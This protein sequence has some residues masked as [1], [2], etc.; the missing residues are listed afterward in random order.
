MSGECEQGKIEE[1]S[2]ML[3]EAV[4]MFAARLDE[5]REIVLHSFEYYQKVDT[6]SK[7]WWLPW[8]LDTTSFFNTYKSSINL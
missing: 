3:E 1:E 5:R 6:V 2:K 7:V 8:Q 4:H